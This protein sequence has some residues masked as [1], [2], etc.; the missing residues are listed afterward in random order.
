MGISWSV[1]ECLEP[2]QNYTIYERV[3]T[4]LITSINDDICLKIYLSTVDFHIR[5]SNVFFCLYHRD[6]NKKLHDTNDD[7][8]SAIE[9]ARGTTKRPYLVGTCIVITWLM[10]FSSLECTIEPELQVSVS[11]AGLEITIKIWSSVH[12]KT[13][14]SIWIS[15]AISGFPVRKSSL[16]RK[17]WSKNWVSVTIFGCPGHPETQ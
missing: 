6:A 10:T 3:Y 2:N 15:P 5:M 7:L 4:Y 9:A 11:S 14:P 8:R 17:P 16:S 12:K 1:T 13:C